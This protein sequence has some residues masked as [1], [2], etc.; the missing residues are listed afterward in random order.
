MMS[1]I[2]ISEMTEAEKVNDE[3]LITIVQDGVNKKTKAKNI[4]TGNGSGSSI[5][6]IQ[7]DGEATNANVYSAEAINNM[8]KQKN[9]ASLIF[10][11]RKTYT[12][13]PWADTLI[14]QNADLKVVGD[15]FSVLDNG[16]KV[17]KDMTVAVSAQISTYNCPQS[18]QFSLKISGSVS[19][20]LALVNSN[21]MNDLMSHQITPIIREVKAGEIIKLYINTQIAG[22]YQVL[23]DSLSAY[24][25]IEEVS[26]KELQ[27]T[28]EEVVER[29]H[30]EKGYYEKYSDGTLKCWGSKEFGTVNISTAFGA[31]FVSSALTL[32]DFPVEFVGKPILTKWLEN[33]STSAWLI[34]GLPYSTTENPRCSKFSCCS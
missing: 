5:E 4:R 10:R 24:L 8:I 25:T 33:G 28:K 16:I 29:G 23:A 7:K 3:D 11:G 20:Y 34:N 6:I 13:A 32:D 30:N 18:S 26:T 31:L 1:E 14:N 17:N 19:G 9:S 15:A 21:T 27:T 22:D 12:L 2:R